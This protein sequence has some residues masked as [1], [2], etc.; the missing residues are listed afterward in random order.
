MGKK[1][2]GVLSFEN[3]NHLLDARNEI[4]YSIYLHQ[5]IYIRQK[6]KSR[7]IELKINNN[8]VKNSNLHSYYCF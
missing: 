8:P 3:N 7:K 1:I 4:K 5:K 2:S 6:N